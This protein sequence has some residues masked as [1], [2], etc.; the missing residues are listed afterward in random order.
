M[1]LIKAVVVLILVAR[2]S[3][4]RKQKGKSKWLKGWLQHDKV[5]VMGDL[6]RLQSLRDKGFF[7]SIINDKLELSLCEALYLMERGK[8]HVSDKRALS[9]KGFIKRAK[10]VDSR[11]WTR[12]KVYSDIRSK[13]YIT[14]AALKF[15]A[16]F[17]V[18]DKGTVPGRHHSKWLL[19]AVSA[20]ESFNWRELSA[21]NR[22]AHSVKK[23]LL[24]GVLDSEGDVTYYST[25]WIKP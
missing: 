25:N 15:G 7:G 3:K 2:K 11:F 6:S 20:D 23:D 12:F 24:V 16:D 22:V 19:F 8:L 1:F 4:S 17:S 13:G 14:R 10:K 21:M 5:V 18:Y 9:L